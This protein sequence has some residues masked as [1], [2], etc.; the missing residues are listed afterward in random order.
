MSR[1]L[2]YDKYNYGIK[3]S[4][5]PKWDK[6]V[7]DLY[8]QYIKECQP[9]EEDIDEE[10]I[11]DIF[12]E[13]QEEIDSS[14]EINIYEL[15]ILI[16]GQDLYKNTK[17]VVGLIKALGELDAIIRFSIKDKEPDIFNLQADIIEED[18]INSKIE[19]LESRIKLYKNIF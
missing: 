11:V 19:N 5:N 2:K 6:Y 18:E 12:N 14:E 10:D 7:T 4:A 16:H 8:N 1:I 13:L 3:E 15:F 9:Y 17:R